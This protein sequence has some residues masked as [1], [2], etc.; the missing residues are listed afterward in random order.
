MQHF[1]VSPMECG[2]RGNDVKV[3]DEDGLIPADCREVSNEIRVNWK[4]FPLCGPIQGVQDCTCECP[5]SQGGT[6]AAIHRRKCHPGRALTLRFVMLAVRSLRLSGH[7]LHART[8]RDVHV[9]DPWHTASHVTL[10]FHRVH[11]VLFACSQPELIS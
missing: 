6:T 2:H 7:V 11:S 3:T 1:R 4:T 10:S 5:R 9:S 8:D